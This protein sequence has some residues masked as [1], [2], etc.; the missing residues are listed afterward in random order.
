MQ[1][2]SAFIQVMDANICCMEFCQQITEAIQQAYRNCGIDIGQLKDHPVERLTASAIICS[3]QR[4]EIWMVGD[5]QCIANHQYVDNPKPYEKTLAERRSAIAQQL[6]NQGKKVEELREKDDARQQILPSLIQ[7]CGEQNISYP[8]I[9][10]FHIPI[11]YVKTIH[12]S[13]PEV[14]LA[15]DG[16]PFLKP[17]LIES[18]RALQQQLETDP[19]NIHTFQATKGW[20]KGNG[21]FD[22]RAY[23]RFL[24]E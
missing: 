20:M 24:I 4:Q 14:V 19:L 21:S 22:D 5:C 6:I 17:T 11:S 10:G 15:S 16:Y 23:I 13:C 7:S 18:E 2:I 12:L 3:L 9:D 1:L 8:V